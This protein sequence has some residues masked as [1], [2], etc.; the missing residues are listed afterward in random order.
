MYY[1]YIHNRILFSHKKKCHLQ[2]YRQTLKTLFQIKINTV[3]FHLHVPSSQIENKFT[4]K[5]DSWS[6]EI[7]GGELDE[8]D[9]KVQTSSYKTSTGDTVYNVMTVVN[10]L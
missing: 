2:Q 8:H 1:I 10:T 5:S 9:Q 6:S 4:E 3:L 7:G